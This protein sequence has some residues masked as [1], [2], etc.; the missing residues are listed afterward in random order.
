MSVFHHPPI[1]V[2]GGRREC[3]SR[4]GAARK[5]ELSAIELNTLNGLIV[6]SI[7]IKL[8]PKKQTVQKGLDVDLADLCVLAHKL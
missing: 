7:S 1:P 2:P 3:G 8:F 6:N 5:E 4:A